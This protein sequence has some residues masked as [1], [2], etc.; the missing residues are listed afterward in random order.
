MACDSEGFIKRKH[1]YSLGC[2]KFVDERKNGEGGQR[3]AFREIQPHART[4]DG[5]RLAEGGIR[6]VKG[7]ATSAAE[8]RH[9]QKREE[10]VTQL[11]PK[12]LE[13]HVN[14]QLFDYSIRP[15]ATVADEVLER[16]EKAKERRTAGDNV[17]RREPSSSSGIVGVKSQSGFVQKLRRRRQ[18]RV[19][20][21]M[22]ASPAWRWSK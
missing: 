21:T 4:W 17:V 1:T 22:T 9:R 14:L 16:S 6:L 12:F 8:P 20:L 3:R 19:N 15:T 13:L 18:R 2:R 5:Q 7:A 11:S 10:K